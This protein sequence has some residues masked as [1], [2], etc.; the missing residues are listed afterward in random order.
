MQNII[1]ILEEVMDFTPDD[2]KANREK[3]MSERQRFALNRKVTRLNR[4]MLVILT[5]LLLVEAIVLFSDIYRNYP[6]YKPYAFFTLIIIASCLIA[7]TYVKR[8][9]YTLDLD[10]GKVC[11]IEGKLKLTYF[12]NRGYR[13]YTAKIGEIWF[14]INKKTFIAIKDFERVEPDCIIYYTPRSR[15]ILSIGA[16]QEEWGI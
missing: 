13:S 5:S 7:Y 4:V 1:K 12:N 11:S 16:S 3:Y 14:D 15:T 8:R 6:A 9:N 2:L 10:E